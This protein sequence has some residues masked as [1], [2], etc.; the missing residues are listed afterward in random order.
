VNCKKLAIDSQLFERPEKLLQR[1]KQLAKAIQGRITGQ[2]TIIDTTAGYGYDGFALALRGH[3]VTLVERDLNM[4]Q[5]LIAFRQYLGLHTVQ[6]E[7][8][9]SLQLLSQ[10]EHQFEVAY[11]DPMFP[12]KK[13]S[14]LP[15]KQMQLLANHIGAGAKEECLNLL[16]LAMQTSRKVVLKR[17]KY[18]PIMNKNQM[19]YQIL[20]Q[21]I[22]FDIYLK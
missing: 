2:L 11:L 17:P 12:T 1:S 20:G 14:A 5:H 13:K 8:A 4:Y 19:T 3:T 16:S 22:R 7:H 18:S 6:I 10:S 9:D 21:S 15:K